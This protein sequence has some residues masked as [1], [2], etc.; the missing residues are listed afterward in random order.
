MSLCILLIILS[1]MCT[2][3]TLNFSRRKLFVQ[4]SWESVAHFCFSFSF[5]QM[6]DFRNMAKLN[7]CFLMDQRKFK[8]NAKLE[9]IDSFPSRHSALPHL[10]HFPTDLLYKYQVTCG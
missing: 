1:T 4:S 7:L 2:C 5:F 3:I 6:I 9:S 8:V 10:N